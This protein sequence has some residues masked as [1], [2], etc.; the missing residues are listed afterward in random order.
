MTAAIVCL[1]AVALATVYLLLTR[2]IN[3][4]DYHWEDQTHDLA[5]R[6]AFLEA[7][8]GLNPDEYL[9]RDDWQAI[10]RRLREK[11]PP[12]ELH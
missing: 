8:L 7:K 11:T 5:V 4:S 6:I 12:E 9:N 1:A 2:R 10:L 3:D